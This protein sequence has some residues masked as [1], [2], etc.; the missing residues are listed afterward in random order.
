MNCTHA[1][2]RGS[3]NVKTYDLGASIFVRLG[4][5]IWPFH[6]R[7]RHSTNL[8][9]TLPFSNFSEQCAYFMIAGW[10]DVPDG[11]WPPKCGGWCFK[12]AVALSNGGQHLFTSWIARND[13]FPRVLPSK[14][15][16]EWNVAKVVI[17]AIIIT[18]THVLDCDRKGKHWGTG[19]TFKMTRKFSRSSLWSSS[20]VECLC[21]RTSHIF[22]HL[23]DWLDDTQRAQP[24]S[25]N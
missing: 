2:V 13:D 14:E 22:A 12:S 8:N 15:Y 4:E 19:T 24:P 11:C 16:S 7:G 18:S 17:S 25:R 6:E 3:R 9:A 20:Q 21:Q 5:G 10:F 1:T 23:S